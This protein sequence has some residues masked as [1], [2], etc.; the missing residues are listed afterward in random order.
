MGEMVTLGVCSF[1]PSLYHVCVRGSRQRVSSQ[2]IVVSAQIIAL[3]A[4]VWVTEYR[5][6]QP[7]SVILMKEGGFG[8][9]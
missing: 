9:S 4:L 5:T 7:D 3:D 1:M 6:L 8:S 2:L